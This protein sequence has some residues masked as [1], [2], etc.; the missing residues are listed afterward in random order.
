MACSRRCGFTLMELVVSSALLSTLML[1]LWGLVNVFTG[2]SDKGGAVA[3]QMRA[4]E[5][6]CA[7]LERDLK[8]AAWLGDAPARPALRGDATSLRVWR[9][10]APS[11]VWLG[12]SEPGVEA[13]APDLSELTAADAA[14]LASSNPS[15]ASLPSSGA[16]PWGTPGSDARALGMDARAASG[17]SASPTTES[18]WPAL[19]QVRYFRPSPLD[20]ALPG[21]NGSLTGLPAANQRLGANDVRD[22]SIPADA[23]ARSERERT[24]GLDDRQ[25]S[26]AASGLP[27]AGDLTRE[28]QHTPAAPGGDWGPLGSR[29]TFAAIEAVRFAYFDGRRWSPRWNSALRGGPPRAVQCELWLRGA[30]PFRRPTAV[31]PLLA[32]DALLNENEPSSAE[33]P[34]APEDAAAGGLFPALDPLEELLI[35]DRPADVVRVISLP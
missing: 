15:S 2:L 9:L 26:D 23:A 32:N 1:G 8:S 11:L 31:D 28:L 3:D 14:P 10:A 21:A 4:A 24:S 35:P 16:T 29:R 25:A 18:S 30:N 20:A 27:L 17:M 6:L 7:G 12:Q 33:T 13:L 22:A 19:V 34:L 5:D